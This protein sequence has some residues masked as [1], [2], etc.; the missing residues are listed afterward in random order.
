MKKSSPAYLSGRTPGSEQRHSRR[1][2]WGIATPV[3]AMLPQFIQTG[4]FRASATSDPVTLLTFHALIGI[5]FLT[6]LLVY[7]L[8]QGPDLPATPVNVTTRF[9]AFVFDMMAWSILVTPVVI[10][11]ALLL[12][13][14]SATGV[15][16]LMP[17]LMLSLVVR[18]VRSVTTGQASFGQ[19]IMS[20]RTIARKNPIRTGIVNTVLA[21]LAHAG[22]F[23]TLLLAITPK[24]QPA[25]WNRVSG[26]EAISTD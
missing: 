25:W 20:Y 24:A 8:Q 12:P 22:A 16:A 23:F 11:I 19:R 15:Q 26:V 9:W 14:P 2:F 3:S 13:D 1:M 10:A 4:M 5:A 21:M 6:G 7:P 18:S 17:I